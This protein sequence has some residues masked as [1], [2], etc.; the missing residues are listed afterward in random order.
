MDAG[1]TS[2]SWLQAVQSSSFSLRPI[3]KRNL[4]VEL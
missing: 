2:L 1:E 3:T 4:K